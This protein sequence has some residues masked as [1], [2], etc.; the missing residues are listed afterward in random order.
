MIQDTTRPEQVYIVVDTLVHYNFYITEVLKDTPHNERYH[1]V[2]EE[3]GLKKVTG[4]CR[5]IWTS[6][7]W[8]LKHTSKLI[9]RIHFLFSREPNVRVEGLTFESESAG[10]T[11]SD[12]G[13]R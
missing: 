12:P 9:A 13:P 6:N 5:I 4:N 8:S 2:K 1:F 7:A 3:S 10:R 11:V